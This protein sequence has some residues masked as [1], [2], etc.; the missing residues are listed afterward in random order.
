MTASTEYR[1]GN[2]VIFVT[3][4]EGRGTDYSIGEDCAN[5]TADQSGRQP[6]C[7]VPFF[8]IYPGTRPPPATPRSSTTIRRP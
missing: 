5:Q 2:T 3:Y 7:H 8:V 4:D 6:S 1:S